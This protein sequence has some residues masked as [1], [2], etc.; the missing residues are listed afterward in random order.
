MLH[1]TIEKHST[2]ANN[3]KVMLMSWAPDVSLHQP[4]RT[5]FCFTNNSGDHGFILYYSDNGVDIRKLLEHAYFYPDVV[6]SVNL[7]PIGKAT[8]FRSILLAPANAIFANVL[9]E[10]QAAG[11]NDLEDILKAY[12]TQRLGENGQRA[13]YRQLDGLK[14]IRDVSSEPL[15]LS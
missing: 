14:H 2:M 5:Q 15:D 1:E 10:Q 11:V 4:K 6:R 13:A 9:T 7:T 8:Q 3:D 12:I